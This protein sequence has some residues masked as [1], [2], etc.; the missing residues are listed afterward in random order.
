MTT[1]FRIRSIVQANLHNLLTMSS[2]VTAHFRYTKSY[3]LSKSW[4]EVALPSPGF[5]PEI[6]GFL[7]QLGFFWDFYF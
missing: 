7:K 3:W 4:Q 5:Y 2:C 1:I 6:S